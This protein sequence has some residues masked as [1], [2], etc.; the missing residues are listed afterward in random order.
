MTVIPGF[1]ILCGLGAL[2]DTVV[3]FG[4][5]HKDKRLLRRILSVGFVLSLLLTAVVAALSQFVPSMFPAPSYAFVLLSLPLLP[6]FVLYSYYY[7]VFQ[8][9]K[10]FGF[11]TKL[12]LFDNIANFVLVVAFLFGFGWGAASVILARLIVYVLDL[13]LF[14]FFERRLAYADTAQWS[15]KE[16]RDYAGKSLLVEIPKQFPG[17]AVNWLL[18]AFVPAVVLGLYY[19]AQKIV[20]G[21]ID[22]LTVAIRETVYAYT[23]ENYKEKTVVQTMVTRSIR[24]CLLASLALFALV[25]I[26]TYPVL[27]LLFPAYLDATPFVILFALASVINVITIAS[28][29]LRTLNF[30]EDTF[31]ITAIYAVSLLVLAV[32]LIPRWG[33]YG[34]ILAELASGLLQHFTYRHYLAKRGFRLSMWP[35]R[36]DLSDM[37]GFVRFVTKRSVKK[38]D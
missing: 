32:V 37:V 16:V 8:S 10:R 15:A 34:L 35:R 22:N 24:I 30:M 33:V 38:K 28:T 19:F 13:L 9:F 7:S 31:K 26:G 25:A 36:E 4:A 20:T 21:A 11:L 6:L 2:Q 14:A 3:N 23:N 17:Q 1:A 27:Y 18:A 5:K 29:Y 12:V